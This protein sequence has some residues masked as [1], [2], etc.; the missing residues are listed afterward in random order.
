VT[1]GLVLFVLGEVGNTWAHLKLRALKDANL[2]NRRRFPRG[3]LFELVSCPH[4]LFEITT[5]VGFALITQVL[6]SWGFLTLGAC[7]LG[8][9]ASARHQAYRRAF[10]GRDGQELYSPKR[11][12][13]VP[14]VF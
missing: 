1:L 13:L 14:F 12:A 10:D 5:W 11:R 6:G 9:Y 3:G 8:Y 4:Y 7:I 2:T